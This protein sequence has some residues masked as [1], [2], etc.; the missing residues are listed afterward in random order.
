MAATKD[1]TNA[2]P[3]PC[4]ECGIVVPAG[5]GRLWWLPGPD[6]GGDVVGRTPEGW[7]VSHHTR[8]DCQQ[9][10]LAKQKARYADRAEAVES[11]LDEGRQEKVEYHDFQPNSDTGLRIRGLEI[12]CGETPDALSIREHIHEFPLTVQQDEWLG[13][14][15][16]SVGIVRPDGL[17]EARWLR[18][19][20]EQQATQRCQEWGPTG[21]LAAEL[22]V[23][24]FEDGPHG[25]AGST[26][27]RAED[28]APFQLG[29]L[30]PEETEPILRWIES[31]TTRTTE[32]TPAAIAKAAK[33]CVPPGTKAE[34][35]LPYVRAALAYWASVES[36]GFDS[37]VPAVAFTG[38]G[39][40]LQ[41]AEDF[42]RLTGRDY[43]NADAIAEQEVR[44]LCK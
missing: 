10:V 16:W 11:L 15:K 20:D 33:A 4:Y 23:W 32:V 8:E 9:A 7:Q 34:D 28:Y 39:E 25:H 21:K 6:D 24:R 5:E 44:G 18:V 19:G 17:F 36:R 1:R 14:V 22:R 26:F 43:T 13:K 35:F 38:T 42:R 31:R 29:Q 2:H 41:F 37:D 3:Q 40:R 30:T 27:P 12:W